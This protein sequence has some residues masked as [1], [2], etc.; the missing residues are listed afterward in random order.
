MFLTTLLSAFSGF[1][2]RRL[3][4]LHT[5]ASNGLEQLF[6]L[7]GAVDELVRPKLV[8]MILN[9]LDECDEQTPRMRSVHYQ[10]LQ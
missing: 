5:A 4:L 3:L 9:E 10:T 7:G 6:Y 8:L 1:S 2:R